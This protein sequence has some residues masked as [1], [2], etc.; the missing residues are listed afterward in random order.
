MATLICWL[1][2]NGFVTGVVTTPVTQNVDVESAFAMWILQM[3]LC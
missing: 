2:M 3:E 1:Q